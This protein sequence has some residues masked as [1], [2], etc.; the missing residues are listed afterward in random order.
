MARTDTAFQEHKTA[1][2][3]RPD[4][5][6]ALTQIASLLAERGAYADALP[7]VD[8]VPV[9]KGP[10]PRAERPASAFSDP[11]EV[12]RI[13]VSTGLVGPPERFSR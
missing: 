9:G 3:L 13:P 5:V 8:A 12:W 10:S 7:V 6:E 11:S 4:Y 2:L 1:A